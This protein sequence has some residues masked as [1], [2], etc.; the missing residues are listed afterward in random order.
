MKITYEQLGM[1]IYGIVY[2]E[3]IDE[4]IEDI[5]EL[6]EYLNNN[7]DNYTEVINL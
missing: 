1:I 5:E 4:E 2:D 7:A 6:I 3:A